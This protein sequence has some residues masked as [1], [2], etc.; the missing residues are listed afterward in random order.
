M[1]P[2]PSGPNHL[3]QSPRPNTV[4]LGVRISTYVFW[5]DTCIQSIPLVNEAPNVSFNKWPDCESPPAS[6]QTMFLTMEPKVVLEVLVPA[7]QTY[8]PS[9]T[10]RGGLFWLFLDCLISISYPSALLPGF[11][12]C[13]QQPKFR[14]LIPVL[15]V[16]LVKMIKS[17]FSG[18]GNSFS[19]FT[20][21][22]I[23][24][25]RLSEEW[26]SAPLSPQAEHS[27]PCPGFAH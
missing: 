9:K 10:C 3:P 16:Q 15:F 4:A 24:F 20:K 21:Y 11:V 27:L 5:G 6:S 2:P 23:V 25:V 1:N 14:A 12:L 13:F 17:W 22:K 7:Y 19:P 18:T 8:L 26:V